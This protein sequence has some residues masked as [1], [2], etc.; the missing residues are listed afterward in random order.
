M[1]DLELQIKNIQEKL[2]LLLRQ[3][4][5]L[6]KE[7]Q[8]LKKEMERVTLLN[9]EKENI[10][11]LLQQQVDV[12]KL[13]GS[14]RSEEERTALEKRIDSYLKEIDKCLALLNA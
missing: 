13:G 5:L 11:Q 2:Q 1:V 10:S 3:Q 6:L 14:S 4:Q 9:Q 8:R 12:L 7:N